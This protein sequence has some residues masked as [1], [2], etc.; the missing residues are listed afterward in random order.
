M[1]EGEKEGGRKEELTPFC[2]SSLPED[3]D[4][5]TRPETEW[6][7]FDHSLRGELDFMLAN[8]LAYDL[9]SRELTNRKQRTR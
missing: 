4:L 5:S 1:T 7:W 6:R 9:D 8:R 3:A 2:P